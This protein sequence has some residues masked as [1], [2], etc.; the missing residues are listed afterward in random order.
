MFALEELFEGVE[1]YLTE[2]GAAV[3]MAF[4]WLCRDEHGGIDSRITWT[5]G[6]GGD[7]V[8]TLAPDA[9]TARIGGERVLGR[10]QQLCRIAITVP[11]D[12]TDPDNE[13]KQWVNTLTLFSAVYAALRAV[14]AGQVEVVSTRYARL[15]ARMSSVTVELTIGVWDQI[16]VP[17]DLSELIPTQAQSAVE[18][19]ELSVTE[20]FLAPSD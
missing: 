9:I 12:P 20:Q 18:L 3:S 6:D 11:G 5:P 7:N 14:G 15:Q 13:R 16:T 1:A 4:G 2:R 19:A 10:Q 17:A 8:G